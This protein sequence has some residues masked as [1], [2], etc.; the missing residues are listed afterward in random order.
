ME[1]S[2]CCSTLASG[3]QVCSCKH[4]FHKKCLNNW[5]LQHKT[6]PLCRHDISTDAETPEKSDAWETVFCKEHVMNLFKVYNAQHQLP[7]PDN[8]TITQFATHNKLIL[9]LMRDETDQ[10]MI[11]SKILQAEIQQYQALRLIIHK[12]N[13]RIEELEIGHKTQKSKKGIMTSLKSLFGHK[14]KPI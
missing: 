12:Q 13:K 3:I 8:S 2:I 10:I 14:I 7:P 6:C 4:T 5:K 1:C 11:S 9:K